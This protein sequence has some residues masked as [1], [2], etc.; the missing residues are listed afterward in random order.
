MIVHLNLSTKYLVIVFKEKIN[1]YN[2]KFKLYG[3]NHAEKK[4]KIFI[5]NT[6]R[7]LIQ[8]IRLQLSILIGIVIKKVININKPILWNTV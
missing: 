6:K 2:Q 7:Y 4:L 5:L 8:I 3:L 1:Y